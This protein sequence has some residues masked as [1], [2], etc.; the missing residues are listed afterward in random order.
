MIWVKCGYKKDCTTPAIY[1]A[2]W[3]RFTEKNICR[4]CSDEIRKTG[5]DWHFIAINEDG[6]E[7]LTRQSY[8]KSVR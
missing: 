4:E 1:V 8:G 2:T 3:D 6:V 5:G 7:E